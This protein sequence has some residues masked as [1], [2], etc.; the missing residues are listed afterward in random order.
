MLTILNILAMAV[1]APFAN[2]IYTEIVT[3]CFIS[4]A[5]ILLYISNQGKRLQSMLINLQESGA[6]L[7]GPGPTTW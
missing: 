6:Q 2:T 7:P 4:I 3:A 5:G 1:T